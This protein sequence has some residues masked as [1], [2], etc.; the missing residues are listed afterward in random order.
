MATTRPRLQSANSEVHVQNA[1]V[2][3]CFRRTSI[4][5]CRSSW[6]VQSN[7][8]ASIQASTNTASF[9]RLL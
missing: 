8:P 7:L 4:Q 6:A 9:C 2:D 5:S 1:E 3:D